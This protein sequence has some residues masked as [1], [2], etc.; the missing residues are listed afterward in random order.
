MNIKVERRGDGW[1]A[2]DETK[3]QDGGCI[4]YGWTEAEARERV[5]YMRGLKAGYRIAQATRPA[6][7][8]E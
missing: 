4:A 2:C 1:V 8:G 3:D 6:Q 5:N 7:G